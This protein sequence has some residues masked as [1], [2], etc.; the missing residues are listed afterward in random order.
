[1]STAS[2]NYEAR[3]ELLVGCEAGAVERLKVAIESL[4][5][6]LCV[7]PHRPENEARYEAYHRTWDRLREALNTAMNELGAEADAHK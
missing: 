1:M 2:E 5:G 3:F 7:Y 4:K 6:V